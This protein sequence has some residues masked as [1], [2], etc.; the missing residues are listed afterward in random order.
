MVPWDAQAASVREC[1]DGPIGP[2]D[3]GVGTGRVA[4]SDVVLVRVR[5]AAMVRAV[6]RLVSKGVNVATWRPAPVRAP[7]EWRVAI[8]VP[9]VTAKALTSVNAVDRVRLACARTAGASR[10]R[11]MVV[12]DIRVM[13][14]DNAAWRLVTEFGSNKPSSGLGC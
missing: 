14:A 8:V 11:G 13:A 4:S 6:D 7:T 2:T 12:P 1:D 3:R 10:V 5:T 9:R